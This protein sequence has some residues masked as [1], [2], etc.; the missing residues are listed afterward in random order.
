MAKALLTQAWLWHRLLSHLNLNTI[1]LLSKNDIVN[2]LPKLKY[3]KDQLCSSCEMGSDIGSDPEPMI[4]CT[5]FREATSRRFDTLGVWKL[6]DKPFGKTVIGIKWLRKNKKDKDNTVIRNKSRLVAK[7]YRQEE[8]ANHAGCL[9]TCK[10]TF[11]GIQFLGD[12][13]VCL[14]SKK[15]DCTAISTAEAEYVALS[16][17]CAQLLWMRTQLTDYGFHFNKIPMYCDSNLA[18]A[19]SCN[20]VLHSRTKHINV[21]YHF[22]KEH[23]E[24]GIVELYFVRTEYQLANM[25]TKALSKERFEYLVGRLGMRCLTPG[26]SGK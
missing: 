17:S 22:I 2:R 10:S 18:I 16:V 25:F 6:V 24:K 8:D 12:K 13:L 23:V 20:P 5:S 15:Q 9:D 4:A 21:R 3:V 1:N 11:R 7:G 19:I 14:S 26:G